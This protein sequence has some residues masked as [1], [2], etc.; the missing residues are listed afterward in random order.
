VPPFPKPRFEYQYDLDRELAALRISD[1]R[2]LW[3]E[4]QTT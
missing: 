4:F 1:H 2:P 3:A